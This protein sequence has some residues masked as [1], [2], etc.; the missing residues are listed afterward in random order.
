MIMTR[1]ENAQHSNRK[2]IL[3]CTSIICGLTAWNVLSGHIPEDTIWNDAARGFDMVAWML[4][5]GLL[6]TVLQEARSR[7]RMVEIV[8]DAIREN[9][10]QLRLLDEIGVVRTFKNR[11]QAMPHVIAAI[12]KAKHRVW[13]VGV[14][15]SEG[16]S[17]RKLLRAIPHHLSADQVRIA[18]IYGVCEAAVVRTTFD[19]A[20]PRF[21]KPLLKGLLDPR[22]RACVYEKTS[23]YRAYAKG[24]DLFAESRFA[25]SI[26]Y[27]TCQPPFWMVIVDDQVFAEGYSFASAC[28]LGVDN[29]AGADLRVSLI[30][31]RVDPR[32]EFNVMVRHFENHW[33]YCEMTLNAALAAESDFETHLDAAVAGRAPYFQRKLDEALLAVTA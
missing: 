25:E 19:A 15:L 18:G 31:P 1:E 33:A 24:R 32:C 17:A 29:C 11:E 10:E 9:T 14:A 28:P 30:E 5:A 20:G 7:D 3:A 6:Y 13:V 22:Q 23:L 12:S 4:S 8:R 26:R 27:Y 21:L 16:L 2:T